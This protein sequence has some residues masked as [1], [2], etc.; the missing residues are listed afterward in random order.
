MKK[1]FTYIICL[2]VFVLR[3]AWAEDNATEPHLVFKKSVLVKQ[4]EEGQV[5]SEPRTVQ[6]GE[7]LWKILREHY[8][9]SN[10]RIAFYCKIAKDINPEVHDLN[11]LEPE[12]NIL[13]PYDYVRGAK[14]E[15]P[16]EPK[17]HPEAE[18]TVSEGEHLWKILR[19]TYKLP[20]AVLFQE[21][22]AMLIKE[23]NP[24]IKDL[25][26]L[27]K[28]QK[29]RIP[30]EL[31]ALGEEAV[32]VKKMTEPSGKESRPPA[33]R[34]VKE[35]LLSGNTLLQESELPVESVQGHE[36]LPPHEENS[37]KEALSSFVRAFQGSD[38]RTGKD[39][40]SIKGGGAVTL[41]YSAFPVY[42]LPWGKKFIFDYG[43]KLPEG[44]KEVISSEWSNT[45]IVAVRERDDIETI[46]G[47]VLDGSGFYKVEKSGE[48]T[49][50]RDNIQISVS[51]NWVVF[52]DTMLKNA[53]I[54]NL[55][56]GEE[57]SVPAELKSYISDMGLN[58]VDIKQSPSSQSRQPSG[59]SKKT[60]YYKVQAEPMILTDLIL[61]IM[62]QK[63]QKDYNTKIFQ[64][65]YSGFSLEVLADRMFE[66]DDATYLIDF[67][68]LPKRI[69]AIIAEQGLHLL[70][71]DVQGDTLS[72]IVKKVFDFCGASYTPPPIKFQYDH[73]EKSN[74]KLTIPGFLLKTNAGD[75]L[76][77]QVSLSE[78][79]MQFLSEID[80]KIIKY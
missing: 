44:L 15:T 75:V 12:Q 45:E 70:Q 41:D 54:V 55:V 31:L 77:T 20:E 65:M 51:G 38:T 47:K 39:V 40:V 58:I 21:K 52:K 8:K 32:P 49:V 26:A 16:S 79:I 1:I 63:Y 76:L 17:Q 59:Y 22:T 35:P 29:I 6:R 23:A 64:N 56:E 68:K 78:P 13:V 33:Q 46:L 10:D 11:T 62:G 14:K 37:V 42:E 7:H 61:D 30:A 28:G 74:I 2:T 66:K 57:A 73:G 25:N 50:N 67:H 19:A 36:A 9:L 24:H 48:Y 69:A 3:P 34:V 53:F 4:Y 72:T 5:Y 71:I 80:V 27:E 60:D 43:E 18:Y